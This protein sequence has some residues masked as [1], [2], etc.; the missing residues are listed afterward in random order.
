MTN[1]ISLLQ[2]NEVHSNEARLNGRHGNGDQMRYQNSD[3]VSG[4]NILFILI[5]HYHNEEEKL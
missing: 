2:V 4:N 3:K 5:S 1:T